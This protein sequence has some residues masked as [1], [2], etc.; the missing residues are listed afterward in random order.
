MARAVRVLADV[1]HREGLEVLG[2]DQVFRKLVSL[3]GLEAVKVELVRPAGPRRPHKVLSQEALEL[4]DLHQAARSG[5]RIY[6][7]QPSA[8]E[9][10][11]MPENRSAAWLEEALRVL[12]QLALLKGE[13]YLSGH[14]LGAALLGAVGRQDLQ[15]HLAG[16]PR[17]EGLS[18]EALLAIARRLLGYPALEEPQPIVARESP[19][20]AP[21]PAPEPKPPKQRKLDPETIQ[22]RQKRKLARFF[23]P[24]EPT[25]EPVLDEAAAEAERA[26]WAEPELVISEGLKLE[27]VVPRLLGLPKLVQS[28]AIN[29]QPAPTVVLASNL[30]SGTTRVPV[31]PSSQAY[32]WTCAEAAFQTLLED[33]LLLLAVEGLNAQRATVFRVGANGDAHRLSG[34]ALTLGG[35]YRLLVP[36]GLVVPPGFEAKTLTDG[37]RATE[38]SAQPETE[39]GL[40][41]LGL[42]LGAGSLE[43]DWALCFPSIYRLGSNGDRYPCFVPDEPLFLQVR[44]LPGSGT[45]KLLV[46]SATSS[47]TV[48]LPAQNECLVA[49]QGLAPGQYALDVLHE[50][51]QVAPASVMFAVEPRAFSPVPARAALAVQGVAIAEAVGAERDLKVLKALDIKLQVPPMWRVDATWHHGGRMPR[52]TA[53]FGDLKGRVELAGLW[54]KLADQLSNDACADLRFDLG[55]LGSWTLP[56]GRMVDVASK[57]EEFRE[58]YR[59]RVDVLQFDLDMVFSQLLEPMCLS[60]GYRVDAP[61]SD[62]GKLRSRLIACE[63]R[64]GSLINSERAGL[65]LVPSSQDLS[66]PALRALAESFESNQV[67]VTNGADWVLV[68]AGRS[69]AR[70]PFRLMTILQEQD[71]KSLEN[72]LA[73]FHL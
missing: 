52:P 46:T 59:S 23:A 16:A 7:S 38:V 12:V 4:L 66:S 10:K 50:S 5:S 57:G 58:F 64:K 17:S 29:S 61:V 3:V 37:W 18:E 53:L 1:V 26:I 68:Q 13:P 62:Q 32:L 44:G 8:P 31:R 71:L 28:L 72:F 36:P 60:L 48:D 19:R 49:L 22:A 63:R 9:A 41:S 27:L 20:P 43:L 67:V 6:S 47:E 70:S 45:T 40:K 25:A 39:A 15:L 65:Y 54:V 21:A 55:E 51:P 30:R 34:Q 33:D 24:A 14:P 56:H 11:A 42:F 73:T 2:Q 35:A 69:F